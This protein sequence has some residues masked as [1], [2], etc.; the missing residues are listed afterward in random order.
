MQHP[1]HK[2]STMGHLHPTLAEC[3]SYV[4]KGIQVVVGEFELLEG[5]QLP[6]PV[7]SRG[8]GVGVHVQ[9][10]RHGRLGLPGHHPENRGDTLWQ[11]GFTHSITLPQPGHGRAFCPWAHPS[12]PPA[13]PGGVH[14]D[15][16]TQGGSCCSRRVWGSLFQHCRL[17]E[18]PHSCSH[19]GF[20]WGSVLTRA[21]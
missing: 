14:W 12:N 17:A 11:W 19:V 1:R 18:E 16:G 7:G 4:S 15:M 6:H 8:R 13:S 3:L 21:L 2:L 10:A 5:H 20:P 9:P